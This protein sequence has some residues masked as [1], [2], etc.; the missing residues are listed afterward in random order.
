MPSPRK[1]VRAT[2]SHT[3]LAASGG[4]GGGAGGAAGAVEAEEPEEE[5]AV[6]TGEE[7]EAGEEDRSLVTVKGVTLPA[8]WMKHLKWDIELPYFKKLASFVKAERKS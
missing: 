8:D 2:K 3:A 5:V 4:G 7:V 1:K 6:A